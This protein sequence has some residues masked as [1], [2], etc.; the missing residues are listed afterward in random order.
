MSFRDSQNVHLLFILFISFYSIVLSI[1][2]KRYFIRKSK[3][4]YKT[5]KLIKET[6]T[7]QDNKPCLS[8]ETFTLHMP[9]WFISIVKYFFIYLKEE[10]LIL[11]TPV[12]GKCHNVRRFGIARRSICRVLAVNL[13]LLENKDGDSTPIMFLLKYSTVVNIKMW[14]RIKLSLWEWETHIGQA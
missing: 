14:S 13:Q 2:F 1:H 6:K 11:R 5:R 8:S 10:L 12:H 7:Q 3:N 4:K 9:I